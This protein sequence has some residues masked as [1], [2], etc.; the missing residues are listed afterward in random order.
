MWQWFVQQLY[1]PS[2]LYKTNHEE[3]GVCA[4]NLTANGR[5]L[6]ILLLN[7]LDKLELVQLFS[8]TES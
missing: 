6:I 8:I 7:L 4:K 1:E 5:A 3:E 2:D